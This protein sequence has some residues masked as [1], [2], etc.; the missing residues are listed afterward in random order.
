MV[1]V[2][3]PF[4][5]ELWSSVSKAQVRELGDFVGLANVGHLVQLATYPDALVNTCLHGG[6]INYTRITFSRGLGTGVVE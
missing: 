6:A 5:L 2:A 4:G 1:L 3:F